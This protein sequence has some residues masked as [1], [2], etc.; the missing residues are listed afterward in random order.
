MKSKMIELVVVLFV[1]VCTF[2]GYAQDTDDEK[3]Q[4][5]SHYPWMGDTDEE[6]IVKFVE[7]V[8]GFMSYSDKD[9]GY[10]FLVVESM[11]RPGGRGMEDYKELYEALRTKGYDLNSADFKNKYRA[12]MKSYYSRI[13]LRP[14]TGRNR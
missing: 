3:K 14:E 11:F 10:A 6:R 8:D 13:A 4:S 12:K 1:T 5:L 7:H 9:A 2:Q